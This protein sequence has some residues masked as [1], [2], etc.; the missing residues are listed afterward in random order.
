MQTDS[1]PT[2]PLGDS[3]AG[4]IAASGP[5]A[6]V[7][8]Q[9]LRFIWSRPGGGRRDWVKIILPTHY[10]AYRDACYQKL[11]SYRSD[12]T[13]PDRLIFNQHIWTILKAD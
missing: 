4:L 10:W 9:C 8:L 2:V 3:F 13:D 5:I 1:Q 11:V 7:G 12:S 6:A